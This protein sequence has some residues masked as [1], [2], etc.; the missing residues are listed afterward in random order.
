MN[1][2]CRIQASVKN[3]YKICVVRSCRKEPPEKKLNNWRVTNIQMDLKW[4]ELAQNNI[5][6]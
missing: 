1:R 3:E 4:I 2:T 5:L 6:L